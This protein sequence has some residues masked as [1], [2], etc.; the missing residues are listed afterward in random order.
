[1]PTG[2]AGKSALEPG[3]AR[4]PLLGSEGGASNCL[5][6]A[7]PI[8][9]RVHPALTVQS[10]LGTA[11]S[12]PRKRRLPIAPPSV[13]P[14]LYARWMAELLQGPLPRETEATCD[15]CAMLPAEGKQEHGS[16]YFDPVAK[17]CSYQPTLP[18]FLVGAILADE[19]GHGRRTVEA[20]ID[21]RV[22]VRPVGLAV[23]PGY[24]AQYELVGQQ[25]FGRTRSLCCPHQLEGGGCGIWLHRNS[26]CATWYCKHLRGGVGFAFWRGGVEPLIRAIE[27]EVA[28]HCVAELGVPAGAMGAMF[29]RKR[30][31]NRDALIDTVDEGIYTKMWGRWRGRERELFRRSAKIAGALSW[32]DIVA[33][34]GPEVR[35]HAAS[36]KESYRALRSKKLPAALRVGTF[37][38]LGVSEAGVRVEAYSDYDLLELPSELMQVL[39]HF[40]GRPVREVRRGVARESGVEIDDDFLRMLLDF[41][42]L[43]DAKEAAE[44]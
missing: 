24:A 37:K 38:V 1:M 13:L 16:A 41:G 2:D 6:G 25:A 31:P 42:I 11:R 20:R 33:I 18:N 15:D 35:L 27:E 17:C 43:V 12:M 4:K 19:D 32:S 3:A 9:G 28:L 23:P 36:A 21:A 30:L 8:I 39:H 5:L 34:A 22:G 26:V 40:D 7:R 29:P 44:A 10:S 14:P